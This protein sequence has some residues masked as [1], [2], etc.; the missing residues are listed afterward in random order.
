[1]P[2]D[3]APA[4][5][6]AQAV[7]ARTYTLRKLQAQNGA[8]SPQ[9]PGADLCDDPTHNQAWVPLDSLEQR[10]GKAARLNIV[11]AVANTAGQIITY[12]GAAID[13]IFHST[14]GGAT[15][16]ASDVWGRDIPYLRSVICQWCTHSPH[17]HEEV[18]VPINAVISKL[19]AKDGA[20]EVSASQFTASANPIQVTSMT[21]TGRVKQVAVGGKTLSGP[22]FR[23]TLGLPSTRVSWTVDG[24][25]LVVDSKG[26]GHGVGLCQYGADGMGRMGYTYKEI[27][28]YYYP[29]TRV[30]V[31]KP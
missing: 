23:T 7:A 13:A 27:L 11:S 16:N 5:L 30:E 17:F 14:C 9:H 29:G 28:A 4:A 8:G 31:M 18:R 19:K 15:E 22:D 6:E 1:M 26:Y 21:L 12:Q 3:F 20:I 10:K 25:D 24:A 2:S